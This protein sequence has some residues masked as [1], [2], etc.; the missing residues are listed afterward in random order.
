MTLRVVCNHS[1]ESSP[2]VFR[3]SRST[4]PPTEVYPSALKAGSALNITIW[5][6]SNQIRIGALTPADGVSTISVRLIR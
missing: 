1:G 4:S 2:S 3:C 6:Y 5:S